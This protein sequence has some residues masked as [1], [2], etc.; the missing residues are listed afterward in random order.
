MVSV[1]STSE[2]VTLT[3]GPHETRNSLHDDHKAKV[4]ELQQWAKSNQ[5][6]DIYQYYAFVAGT[7]ELSCS[8]RGKCLALY[9]L[10]TC[11]LLQILSPHFIVRYEEQDD[12]LD[13]P[14]CSFDFPNPSN[15]KIL[16]VLLSVFISLSLYNQVCSLH[17]EGMYSWNVNQPCFISK[18]WIG[19]GSLMNLYVISYSWFVSIGILHFSDNT[20]DMILNSLALYFL[21][22]L[23]NELVFASSYGHID[24]WLNH[25]YSDFIDHHNEHKRSVSKQKIDE[26]CGKCMI[27]FVA[28]VA[29]KKYNQWFLLPLTFLAP[30]FLVLCY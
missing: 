16:A 8:G 13:R 7:N 12:D 3:V 29:N 2:Y 14:F 9:R 18:F 27:R 21:V 5:H 23:D 6:L 20:F 30:L 11:A 26:K 22:E 25:K 28:L 15:E 24:D 19:F 10:I 4:K 17:S 1:N